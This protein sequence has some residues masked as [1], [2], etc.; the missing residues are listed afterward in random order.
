MD[1]FHDDSYVY[2]LAARA[3]LVVGFILGCLNLIAY[4]THREIDFFIFSIHF[5]EDRFVKDFIWSYPVY[6]SIILLIPVNMFYF[7]KMKHVVDIKSFD[8]LWWDKK[9]RQ[10]SS[11]R[12]IWNCRFGIVLA[13]LMMCFS[14]VVGNVISGW[15]G[16]YADTSAFLILLLVLYPVLLVGLNNGALMGLVVLKN[17]RHRK[18]G[19]AIA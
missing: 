13:A 14:G 7:I 19:K 2:F 17:Y 12:V 10:K 6:Y 11:S 18:R 8:S 16:R 15:F 9:R 3:G 1:K 4:I 5:S